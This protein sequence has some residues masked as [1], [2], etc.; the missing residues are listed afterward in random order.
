MHYRRIIKAK[1]FEQR[2]GNN[3]TLLEGNECKRK[4]SQRGESKCLWRDAGKRSDS[5]YI[6]DS[7]WSP[8]FHLFFCLLFGGG[9]E[10]T[11]HCSL[12]PE[13]VHWVYR[14]VKNDFNIKFTCFAEKNRHI[15][16]N[17]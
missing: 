10:A 14:K 15:L 3:R 16:K 17:K 1:N 9:I 13:S 12:M 2:I 7:P 4:C 6:S 5:P 8:K 11:S